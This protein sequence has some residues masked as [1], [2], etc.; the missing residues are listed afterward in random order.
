VLAVALASGHPSI[1]LQD[2]Q[3]PGALP[4]IY[5][6]SVASKRQPI[7]AVIPARREGWADHIA[8]RRRRLDRFEAGPGSC[9]TVSISARHKSGSFISQIVGARTQSVADEVYRRQ[10][11]GAYR[12]VAIR[13]PKNSTV[14][15]IW[16]MPAVSASVRFSL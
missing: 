14:S 6:I 10:T 7:T 11:L 16:V 1:S 5:S 2:Q 15:P 13:S 8:A 9:R 4:S 3:D 12:P